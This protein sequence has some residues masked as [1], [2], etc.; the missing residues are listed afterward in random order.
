MDRAWQQP[1]IEGPSMRFLG[2]TYFL[3][4]SA[5][6]YESASYAMGYATCLSPVGPCENV[7]VG[8]PFVSSAGAALGP[9]GGEFFDDALGAH[10]LVYHAWTAPKTTYAGGGARSMRID[11]LAIG[12][13]GVLA[14]DG[15][16]TTTQSL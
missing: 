3:V 2:G 7:S 5:N 6:N 1:I 8:G 12:D 10:W 11:R 15:P 14:L 13:G 4:Y 16:T 9:G